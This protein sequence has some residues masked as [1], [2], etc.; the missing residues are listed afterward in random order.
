MKKEE[1]GTKTTCLPALP[2]CLQGINWLRRKREAGIAVAAGYSISPPPPPPPPFWR[3]YKPGHHA[4]LC[5][6]ILL[7]FSKLYILIKMAVS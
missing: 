6:F 4:A 3:A 1:D 7:L 5:G 2:A